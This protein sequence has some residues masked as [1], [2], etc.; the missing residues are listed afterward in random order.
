[1]ECEHGGREKR[2]SGINR[3][4]F[5]SLGDGMKRMPIL[6]MLKTIPCNKGNGAPEHWLQ[7]RKKSKRILMRHYCV[8]GQCVQKV[9]EQ[10]IVD[11]VVHCH[12]LHPPVQR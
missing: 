10:S 7:G 8:C 1:M 9:V 5:P 6:G 12:A 11:F 2:L 3:V 4:R